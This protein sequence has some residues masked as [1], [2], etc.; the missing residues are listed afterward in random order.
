MAG[1]I[2]VEIHEIHEPVK[3][4]SGGVSLRLW[5][6]LF[7]ACLICALAIFM[8]G[9]NYYRGFTTNGSIPY[10]AS[11]TFGFLIAAGLLKRNA[12]YSKYWQITYAFCTASA[13]NLVSALFAG[14]N[15]AILG[16]FNL[17]ASTNQGMAVAKM[18]DALLVVIPILV[19]VKFSG[20]NLGSVFLA[21]GNLKWGLG[22][23]S[24]VL[25]NFVTS[26]LIFFAPSYNDLAVLGAATVW[27]GVFAISNGFLEELWLRGLFLKKLVPFFG[28]AGSVLL[29]SIWFSAMHLLSVAYL[30]ASVVPV[31]LVNTFT[32]GLA[33]G[34]LILKTNSIWGAVLIHIAADWFLF[35]ATLAIR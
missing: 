24:L 9:T 4:A 22:I 1:L 2:P 14:Y 12:R 33:C 16:L 13:V 34:Y 8:F 21:R 23:G 6:S 35:I 26:A 17:T 18:Y 11:L 25:F 30:P 29:T 27:G 7:V 10:T 3:G 32:L 5:V 31:F 19:M 20:A 28:V 15:T